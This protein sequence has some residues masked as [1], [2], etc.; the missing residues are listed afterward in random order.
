MQDQEHT[1]RKHLT[2]E[3]VPQT[4]WFSNVR[5]EVST[6]DWD[7]LRK[8]TA[9]AAG[10]RCQICGGR[11]PKWPVECHEI[12]EYED[13]R[14]VQTLHGLLALCPACHEV[15]HMGL[16]NVR[17]RGQIAARHLAKVN[18]WT[19]QEAE[20]YIADQFAV[21]ESRSRFPWR[22]DMS[23]LEQHGVTPKVTAGAR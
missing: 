10:H 8:T 13:Q 19:A 6:A 21:W 4:C 11:G 2:I 12:W 18:G 3:L 7:R 1:E 20:R 14:H 17:G 22:L 9:H 23:W 16:A 15:K 5:S